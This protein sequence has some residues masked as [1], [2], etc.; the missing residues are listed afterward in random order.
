MS[1]LHKLMSLEKGV[2]I[3]LGVLMWKFLDNVMKLEKAIWS[4]Y[5]KCYYIV[6]GRDVFIFGKIW[7]IECRKNKMSEGNF[8]KSQ[9]KKI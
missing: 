5:R 8:K 3:N 2:K 1:K 4:R 9:I 6:V 7:I